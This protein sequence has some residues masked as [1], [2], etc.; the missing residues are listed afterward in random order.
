VRTTRFGLD[1]QTGTRISVKQ[2]EGKHATFFITA[3]SRF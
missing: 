2:Q 1:V 3:G